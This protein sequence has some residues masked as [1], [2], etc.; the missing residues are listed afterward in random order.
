LFAFIAGQPGSWLPL[1]DT[2]SLWHW[3]SLP[4]R[5]DLLALCFLFLR[6]AS[7][8]IRALWGNRAIRRPELIAVQQQRLH[9]KLRGEWRR[10]IAS[11]RSISSVA[12]FLGTIGVCLELLFMLRGGAMA[13]QAWLYVFTSRAQAALFPLAAGLIVAIFANVSHNLMCCWYDALNTRPTNAI[14]AT[15]R[16]RDDAPRARLF[17]G[18]LSPGIFGGLAG[19]VMAMWLIALLILPQ[20]YLPHGLRVGIRRET[21]P[22]EGGRPVLVVTVDARAGGVPAVAVNAKR[23]PLDELTRALR[24]EPSNAQQP[25]VY[26]EADKE[27]PWSQVANVIA[28]TREVYDDVILVTG[29]L[30]NAPSAGGRNRLH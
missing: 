7:I 1:S 16:S 12:P 22:F 6:T 23:I 4:V 25:V 15:R 13:R 8:L 19:T 27:L 26:V 29:S 2:P 17:G 11:L 10:K 18:P 3:V 14:E 30:K 28:S 20:P 5:L 21:S 24:S 9:G